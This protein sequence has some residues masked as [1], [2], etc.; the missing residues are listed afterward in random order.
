MRRAALVLAGVLAFVL[1]GAGDAHAQG[2]S[3]DAV[4]EAP[5]RITTLDDLGFGDTAVTGAM[6]QQT[7]FFA[8]HGDYEIGENSRVVVD[9]THSNLLDPEQSAVAI[10]F[11]E[12]PLLA[13]HLDET[14]IRGGTYE[15]PIPSD[16]VQQDFN[17]LTF[18]FNMTTGQHCE[19]SAN[20]ALFS[21][22]LGS[23]FFEMDFAHD[24]PVPTLAEDNL[25]NYPYPFFRG[26]Y[27]IVAPV[28]VGIPA[29]PTGDDLTAAY[30]IATGLASRVFF[31]LDLVRVRRVDTL[32]PAELRRHQ[33]I[34]LGSPDRNPLILRAIA[35]A[36]ADYD[37]ATNSLSRLGQPLGEDD[38]FLAL[39]ES[40]WNP[41]YRA[42]IVSGETPAAVRRGVDALTLDEPSALLAGPEAVLLEPVI[43]P[44]GRTFQSAFTFMD[45]GT[46]E[47]TIQGQEGTVSVA[48]SA[49]AAAPGS[50]GQMDLVLS[51]PDGLDT[52]RTNLI[53]DLNGKTI[54]TVLLDD[55]D[56][57]R[58]SYRVDLPWD[59]LR[60][61]PNAL[62]LRA[63]LYSRQSLVLAPCESPAPERLW[64]TVH[65]DSAIQLPQVAGS[66][67]GSSLSALPFP[68]AGFQGVRETTLVVNAM[69]DQA[70]RAGMLTM[71]ALGRSFG[72]MNEFSVQSVREAT[73]ESLGDRHVVAIA[74]P[75][76]T[77][78]GQALEAALPLVLREGGSRALVEEAGTLT[79]ILDSSRIG[80]IQEI[81]VPWAPGRALL[82]ITGTDSV[83]LGWAA[84]ALVSRSLDGNVALLQ[85]ATQ[86]NTFDLQRVHILAPEQALEDRFSPEDTRL[87]TILAVG[88]IGLGAVALV[89]IY[90]LRRFLWPGALFRRRRR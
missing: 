77:P 56:H 41:L 26:G 86:I 53:V 80:A 25:S 46:A 49:P 87:R 90:G 9:L 6:A 59:V 2:P 88:L 57:R 85:S 71:I 30:Q 82:S 18:T 50:V 84:D 31:E 67:T 11:N 33:L 45:A 66:A 52:R 21:T 16:L 15:I 10:A 60:I 63:T 78:L 42:L 76:A 74:V 28:I 89:V 55:D 8:G 68:F 27:P 39:V 29:N 22:I 61:G 24:P 35:G 4:K 19:S 17:R 5:E 20:A 65:D 13:V 14:N 70:L 64:I 43:P 51:F 7:I 1:L 47:H 36:E 44:I 32:S 38:G 69:D 81:E 40:P 73:P 48:F 3:E 79:E 72:A 23:T 37:A 54:A 12:R 34:L 83:A 75:P 62:T 58:G